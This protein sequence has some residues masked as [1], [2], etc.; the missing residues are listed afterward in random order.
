[1]FDNED[2]YL[3]VAYGNFIKN[4]CNNFDDAMKILAF[5]KKVVSDV[6]VINLYHQVQVSKSKNAIKFWIYVLEL[7]LLC[8][9]IYSIHTYVASAFSYLTYISAI[10]TLINLIGFL[11]IIML[12]YSL[13]QNEDNGQDMEYTKLF[14]IVDEK[15]NQLENKKIEFIE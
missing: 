15:E 4:S 14:G 5:Y 12:I 8:L 3:K 9:N 1:L 2:S 11:L 7:F 13:S 6:Y 10:L